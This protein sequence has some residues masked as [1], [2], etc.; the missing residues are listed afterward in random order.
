MNLVNILPES[1]RSLL[2]ECFI[3]QLACLLR[4]ES[5]G[6]II[7]EV[8][9][10]REERLCKALPTL[11]VQCINYEIYTAVLLSG[12][13]GQST[14]LEPKFISWL[15]HAHFRAFAVLRL[16]SAFTT[17]NVLQVLLPRID[18]PVV[19]FSVLV[20]KGT[21]AVLEFTGFYS[22]KALH[23]FDNLHIKRL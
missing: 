23:L 10:R 15:I 8:E 7:D 11:A 21:K 18:D 6:L 4:D 14:M 16:H 22:L 17:V 5:N 20:C 9:N 1:G 2:I 19:E 12:L 3:L 13:H